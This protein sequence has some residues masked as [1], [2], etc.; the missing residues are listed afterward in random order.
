[1]DF[2]D[3]FK[4]EPRYGILI[5]KSCAFA[6]A[7]LHL[8]AHITKRHALA[9]CDA[10]GLDPAEATSIAKEKAAA[11]L[12]DWLSAE[13]RLLDPTSVRIL[14]PL[15]TEP[16]LPELMLHHGYQCAQCNLV[17]G[18]SDDAYDLP[19][20]QEGESLDNGDH[21]LDPL[22]H[23]ER[24]ARIVGDPFYTVRIFDGSAAREGVFEHVKH[25]G[26]LRSNEL[27]ERDGRMG[28]LGWSGCIG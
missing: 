21:P 10:T 4:F 22:R 7:P 27:P 1:M 2:K 16:P 24:I 9:A 26:G 8:R 18:I 15:P 20:G 28:H 25:E 12:A 11:T 3:Q 14:I 17:L 6:V 19:S 23:D 13:Y 5:C